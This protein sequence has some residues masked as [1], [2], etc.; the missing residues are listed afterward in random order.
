MK[1]MSLRISVFTFLLMTFIVSCGKSNNDLPPIVDTSGGKEV[2]FTSVNATSA[3]S[4]FNKYLYN[5]NAKLYYR[6]SDKSGIAAIWTQAIYFDMA[7]N[8]YKRTN[9]ATYKTRVHD[10]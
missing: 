10:V 6:A 5:T 7:M 2:S 9:D 3:Y 1:H 4:D 8:A